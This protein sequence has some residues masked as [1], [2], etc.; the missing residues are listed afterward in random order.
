MISKN[1]AVQQFLNDL[2]IAD[3]DKYESIQ[4]MRLIVLDTY[5][6]TSERI[7]YGGIM[8][9]LTEDFGGLFVSKNHISFEFGK[10]YLLSDPNTFLE[11]KGKFRRHLK[12]KQFSDIE[13]KTVDFFVNQ[14]ESLD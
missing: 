9:T 2:L 6:K 13:S 1:E 5:P 11:G 7:I 14:V 3:A 4:K 12:I 8:F 10:G